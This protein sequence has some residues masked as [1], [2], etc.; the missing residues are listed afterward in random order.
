MM[1]VIHDYCVRKHALL[2]TLKL[3]HTRNYPVFAAPS[4]VGRK[5]LLEL[6][7][8]SEILDISPPIPDVPCQCQQG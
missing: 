6:A 5:G 7:D 4:L 8:P 2:H 3:M 1:S